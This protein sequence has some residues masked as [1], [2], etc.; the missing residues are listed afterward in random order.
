MQAQLDRLGLDYVF[1]RAT[2]YRDMSE[3]GL[4]SLSSKTPITDP[5]GRSLLACA[6][7]HLDVCRTI[8]RCGV[9]QALVLEDDV[10]L[11]EE[12]PKILDEVQSQALPGSVILLCYYSHSGQPLTL[13]RLSA[14]TVSPGVVLCPPADIAP[15][16]S[17]AAYIITRDVAAKMVEH[18]EQVKHVADDW[19]SFYSKGVFSRLYCL[20][21]RA[22]EEAPFSTSIAY[23]KVQGLNHRIK[24][25][26]RRIAPMAHFA[27]RLHRQ[28]LARKYQLVFRDLPPFWDLSEQSVEKQRG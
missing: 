17:G 18:M 22:V 9:D 16:A 15:V 27:N 26:V 7:S 10:V 5:F 21:P 28:R 8:V 2:D 11:S 24:S 4:S 13:T 3:D 1:V 23:P 20:Y 25:I 14:Q 19:G 6:L 12:L